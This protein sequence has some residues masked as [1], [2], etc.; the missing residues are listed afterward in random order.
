MGIS[1]ETT[2]WKGKGLFFWKL[3]LRDLLHSA[4]RGMFTDKSVASFLERINAAPVIKPG[5]LQCRKDYAVYLE[6]S[7]SV[8][9]FHPQSFPW[10][11]TDKYCLDGKGKLHSYRIAANL[12]IST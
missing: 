3:V 9:V 1:F 4:G 6:A 8:Y 10:N 2:R 11:K 12:H 7:G 5:W